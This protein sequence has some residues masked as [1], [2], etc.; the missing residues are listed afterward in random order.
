MAFTE[1]LKS[2]LDPSR[3]EQLREAL[4]PLDLGDGRLSTEALVRVVRAVAARPE[5][6]ED[7][8]VDDVTN[9]WWL[10]LYREANYEIRI[11]SW[12]RDQSS[13]WHDH[14][15][16]SGAFIF[17]AG[18]VIEYQRGADLI[19]VKSVRYGAGD[20]GSFGPEHVHDMLYE[21]GR[22]AVSVHAYSPPLKGLTFY[23]RT[24]LGFVA[25]EFV[26]EEVRSAAAGTVAR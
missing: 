16:S 1:S 24:P 18:T 25:R 19:E 22:P 15:G 6:F 7:L 21:S 10:L 17:S 3:V 26:L 5:L 2:E 8:V 14:G 11:L 12:E 4:A 13:D 20:Y 9:R 23:D